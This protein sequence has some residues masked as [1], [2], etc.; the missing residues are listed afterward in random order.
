MTERCVSERRRLQRGTSEMVNKTPPSLNSGFVLMGWGWEER[1]RDSYLIFIAA[2]QR[3][4]DCDNSF[5]V[6][7]EGVAVGLQKLSYF[8]LDVNSYAAAASLWKVGPQL[9]LIP[10]VTQ[11]RIS[12]EAWWQLQTE[13]DALGNLGQ[14]FKILVSWSR[15]SWGKPWG[16]L[17]KSVLSELGMSLVGAGWAGGGKKIYLEGFKK[18][19]RSLKKKKKTCQSVIK[20]SKCAGLDRAHVLAESDSPLPGAPWKNYTGPSGRELN[21]RIPLNP[22]A[23]W[24]RL[25]AFS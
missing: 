8:P 5:I 22:Q 4:I 7:G 12:N 15:L 3:F 16:D 25:T 2:N 9:L 21:P 10:L 6:L 19:R 18:K 17:H 23:P 1:K 11:D 20:L 13:T 14:V 24:L